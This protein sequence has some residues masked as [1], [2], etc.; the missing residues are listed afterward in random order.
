MGNVRSTRGE[1]ARWKVAIDFASSEALRCE[2]EGSCELVVGITKSAPCLLRDRV[3]A[4]GRRSIEF[5]WTSVRM[6]SPD[7]FRSHHTPPFRSATSGILSLD[8]LEEGRQTLSNLSLS[9]SLPARNRRQDDRLMLGEVLENDSLAP[10]PGLVEGSAIVPDALHSSPFQHCLGAVYPRPVGRS[11]HKI[12][13]DGV[14]QHISEPGDLSIRFAGDWYVPV[15]PSPEGP[16][17]IVEFSDLLGEIGLDRVHEANK[18]T[19]LGRR[20]QQVIVGAENRDGVD[21]HGFTPLST[22][23]HAQDSAI[24]LRAWTE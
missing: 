14:C 16:L 23:D 20:N 2:A 24:E 15:P 9:K 1:A 4:R 13:L 5:L 11:R 18:G 8:G 7:C 6:A 21:R 17:P 12:F 3:E 10:A 22:T 19:R